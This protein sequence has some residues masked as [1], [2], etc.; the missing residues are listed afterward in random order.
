MTEEPQVEGIVDADVQS[1]PPPRPAPKVVTRDKNEREGIVVH[2][3]PKLAN[4]IQ[5]EYSSNVPPIIVEPDAPHVTPLHQLNEFPTWIDCPYCKKRTMT[6]ITKEDTS[7]QMVVGLV[8]C[9][10][11]VCLACAPCLCG[12]FQN[13]HIH[14]SSCG[15]RIATIPH[16]GP[17]QLAPITVNQQ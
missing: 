15:A 9:L 12:W 6:K 3:Q 17:I 4:I 14:C 7:M 16:D 5:E 2:N 11:C 1:S 10:F 13:T 8:L